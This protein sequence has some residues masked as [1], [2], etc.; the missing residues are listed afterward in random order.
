[1]AHDALVHDIPHQHPTRLSHLEAALSRRDEQPVPSYQP[2][3]DANHPDLAVGYQ[4]SHTTRLAMNGVLDRTRSRS[5]TPAYDDTYECPSTYRHQL[6][7]A[8]PDTERSS[9]INDDYGSGLD[10]RGWDE[11][12]G[13]YG[14]LQ[15]EDTGLVLPPFEGVRS[16]NVA[17]GWQ[18][19]FYG[20]D[21][22]SPD[23]FG[24]SGDLAD[25]K[26]NDDGPTLHF[27][28]APQGRV[29]RRMNHAGGHRNFKQHAFLDDNGNYSQ[30][31]P[32]PE[33]LSSILPVKGIPEQECTRYV[34]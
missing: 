9:L 2:I 34:R 8:N 30:N 25:R 15:E 28:P 18:S 17:R 13:T 24:D 7:I 29:G 21:M 12:L 3:T 26:D 19:T 6:Q 11:K 33:R 23:R 14:V 31:L 10:E 5:P 1:M 16:G 20:D 22:K 4:T 27:G 32:I